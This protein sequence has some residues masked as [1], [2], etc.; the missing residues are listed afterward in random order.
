MAAEHAGSVEHA[1]GGP[2]GPAAAAAAEEASANV[3]N[4]ADAAEELTSS[5]KEI[6]QQVEKATRVV[7]RAAELSNSSNSEIEA[8][9]GSAQKIGDVVG[10]R[11]HRPPRASLA[12]ASAEL[13]DQRIDPALARLALRLFGARDAFEPRAIPPISS[14]RSPPWMVTPVSPPASV[15]V[16]PT[17][18]P[19]GRVI[20]RAAT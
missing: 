7:R 2:A 10:L 19:R 6:G 11:C 12:N 15:S 14:L 16:V 9:A 20:D 4:V 1:L 8:L 13:A 5:I 3:Q 18:L 17:S